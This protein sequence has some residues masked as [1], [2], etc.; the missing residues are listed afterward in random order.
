MRKITV[1]MVLF[2]GFQLLDIAGPQDAFAEVRRLSQGDCQYEM[3]TVATTRGA[4]SSSSGMTVMPDRTIF[5]PCPHFDT[6]ILPG[7]TGIFDVL[8]DSTLGAWL[9]AQHKSARR[10]AAICN[11]VFALGAARLIDHRTVTTHW[12]DA[13]RLAEMFPLSRVEADPIHHRDGSIY[14]T[15]G[16]TAGIDL[17]LLMIEEDF[18]KKLAVAVAKYLV[19]YL[20]RAGGQSQFSPLLETQAHTDSQVLA[21]QD[22]LLRHLQAGHS[23]QAL[24]ERV[25]MSPRNLSR[26][27]TR[28]T[29]KPPMAFLAD[30]RIDAARRYLETTEL[31]LKEIA[32][33]CGF[34]SSEALRRV[35][36]KRLA[37]NPGDYRQRFHSGG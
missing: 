32:R 6:V 9:V 12:M 8:E 20:R 30:A 35:F 22:Y 3:L 36:A 2:P 5:D 28:E 24:A 25:H 1:A 18:G 29:G 27:F 21:T 34:D 37:I 26:L 23:L 17:A 14:T 10:L 33:H 31:S 4:L 16:V 15:A 19:V 7:G 11:G 13:P